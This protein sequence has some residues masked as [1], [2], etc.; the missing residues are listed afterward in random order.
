MDDIDLVVPAELDGGNGYP[1]FGGSSQA[2]TSQAA[3]ERLFA[4]QALQAAGN[5][6]CRTSTLE[7][8][9]DGERALSLVKS[10]HSMGGR[11]FF[12]PEKDPSTLGGER[13]EVGQFLAL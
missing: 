10:S 13:L 3:P 11:W 7:I 9:G 6:Q 8:G 1:G 5:C 12:T 4:V 2:Q